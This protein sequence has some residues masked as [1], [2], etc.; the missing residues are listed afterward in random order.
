MKK[1]RLIAIIIV[2]VL[3]L[4]PIRLIVKDGGS[5]VYKAILYEAW[6]Y[7]AFHVNENNE[8]TIITG[9]SIK[10]LG[11]EVFNNASE[12]VADT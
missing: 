9:W 7:H 8:D 2:L 10:I 11:M 1:K 12:K 4:T 6:H 3:L 5:V